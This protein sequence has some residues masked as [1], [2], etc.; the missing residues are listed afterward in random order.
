LRFDFLIH[1]DFVTWLSIYFAV[2][3]PA[4]LLTFA[5]L[6]YRLLFVLAGAPVD[7]A[8]FSPLASIFLCSGLFLSK[9]SAALWPAIGLLVSDVLINAH[10]HAS[11]LDTRMIP[12]YFCFGIIFLTGTRLRHQG[13]NRPIPVLLAAVSSSIFFYLVTNTVGWYFDAAIPLSVPLYPKTFAGWAQALTVGHPGFPP[14]YLFLRNTL[15]SDLL[16][17]SLFLLTQALLRPQRASS[18]LPGTFTH[19]TV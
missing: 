12:G 17:T 19:P 8:N 10:F 2:M 15:V 11:L 7:W 14:T 3:V 5:A 13:I 6:L 4:L 16:F 18:D 9:K 1:V